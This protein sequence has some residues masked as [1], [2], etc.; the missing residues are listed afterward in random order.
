VAPGRSLHHVG[1]TLST[2]IYKTVFM[3]IRYAI[4]FGDLNTHAPGCSISFFADYSPSQY[5]NGVSRRAITLHYWPNT[6]I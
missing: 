2:P 3:L 6:T 4:F 5:R 1:C